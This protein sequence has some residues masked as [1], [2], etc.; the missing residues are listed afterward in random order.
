MVPRFLVRVDRL[1][2]TSNGKVD[3]KSLTRQATALA[4]AA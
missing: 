1:P 4:A 2:L 3:R